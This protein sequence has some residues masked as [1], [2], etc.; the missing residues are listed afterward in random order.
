MFTKRM[1]KPHCEI[2][3]VETASEALALSIREKASVDLGYMARLTGKTQEEI[4]TELQGVIF[5]VRV[6]TASTKP[7]PRTFIR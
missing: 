1:I 7:S 3:S 4:V 2:T 6:C 5:R